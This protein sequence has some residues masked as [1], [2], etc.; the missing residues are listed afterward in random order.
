[1]SHNTETLENCISLRNVQILLSVFEVP[2]GERLAKNVQ[3]RYVQVI[4]RFT[5]YTTFSGGGSLDFQVSKNLTNILM[6]RKNN[7]FNLYTKWRK[8]V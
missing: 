4:P 7:Y 6:Y 8:K 1:M 5:A 3:K 2:Y